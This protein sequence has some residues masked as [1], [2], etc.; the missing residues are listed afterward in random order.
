[1][2]RK[3]LRN[4][5]RV[6]AEI[7]V[8]DAERGVEIS[9]NVQL[10]YIADD[11]RQRNDVSAGVGTTEAAVVG[12]NAVLSLRVRTKN[13]VE[14]EQVSFGVDPNA[15]GLDDIVRIWA[16]QVIPTITGAAVLVTPLSSGFRIPECF[17]TAGTMP[18]AAIPA[19]AFRLQSVENFAK[20]FF[21]SGPRPDPGNP[22]VEQFVNFAFNSANVATSMGVRW[23]ELR[24]YP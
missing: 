24:L 5:L 17:V 8:D 1:M 18:T 10:V 11:L 22:Q 4:F 14:I 15:F 7:E 9:E 2:A 19:T 3:S 21:V 13:G 12:E 16:T 20:G 23:R 6:F